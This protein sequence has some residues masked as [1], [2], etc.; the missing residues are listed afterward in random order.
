MKA[1]INIRDGFKHN[2]MLTSSVGGFDT[3]PAKNEVE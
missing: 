3:I 2:A 1:V